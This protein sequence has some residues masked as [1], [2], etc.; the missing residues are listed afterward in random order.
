MLL[1]GSIVVYS[2]PGVMTYLHGLFPGFDTNLDL[3]Y[4]TIYITVM[5]SPWLLYSLRRMEDDYPDGNAAAMLRAF[6]LVVIAIPMIIIIIFLFTKAMAM[7]PNVTI[8]GV[9]AKT[10]VVGT[11]ERLQE[12]F[13]KTGKRWMALADQAKNPGAYYTGKVEENKKQPL[14]VTIENLYS[15]DKQVTV[16]DSEIVIVGEVK[17]KSFIGESILVTPSCAIESKL[18]SPAMVDPPTMEIIYSTTQ[19]FQCTFPPMPKTGTYTVK[20]GASFPFE[21]WA[22]IPYHFVDEE[23]AR[24]IARQGQSVQKVLGIPAESVATYTSGP[25]RVGMGGSSMP[26]LV[27]PDKDPIMMPGSQI[28]LTIDNGWDTGGTIQRVKRIELKVPQP[29]VLSECTRQLS[30]EPYQDEREP[31]YTDF[32]F[33]NE[34]VDKNIGWSSITCKLE[35][36]RES[37]EEAFAM[38]AQGDAVTR[39][40]IAVV[41]YDYAVEK[42]TTVQVK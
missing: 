1:A 15:V 25:V 27:R 13:M 28:G 41:E 33:I 19:G 17:A 40:F 26:L 37:A 3:Y 12:L 21:T 9:D 38:V 34:G 18:A 35:I 10:G 7:I 16:N 14:G 11:V 32:V 29:F 36:P 30:R 31:T 2:L 4:A 8:D 23:R 6:K 24:N 39:S 20:S 5:V 22:Y 42:S